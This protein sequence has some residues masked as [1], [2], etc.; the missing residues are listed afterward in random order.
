[1][2]LQKEYIFNWRLIITRI[3]SLIFF[4]ALIIYTLFPLLTGSAKHSR[5]IVVYG[6]SILSEVMNS[7]IFPSFAE[8]WYDSTGE[9][10]NF[11]SSFAGSGTV[12]NQI[13]M[14]VPAEVAILSL[15]LDAMR[16]VEKNI[17]PDN[18]WRSLPFQ[19]ILNLTPF[20]FL[21]RPGNPKDINDFSDLGKEGVG[22]VHPD[23]LTSGG[24]QW[25]ILAEYGSLSL[26]G[27]KTAAFN[28]LLSIWNNV[29]AQA[30]SARAARTQF[31]NGFGD[32]LITYEQEAL[33]DRSRN[34]LNAE[35]IY[36]HSTILS[37][38]TV[39]KISKNISSDQNSLVNA[40]VNFLWTE[41]AQKIFVKYGFRS[42]YENL[43]NDKQFGTIEKPFMV[44]DLGGWDIAKK[45]IIENIW[46]AK[47]VRK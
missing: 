35:I 40:F 44:K 11:I 8:A 5:T 30:A 34:K 33:Y 39:V 18:S 45:E 28:Q 14:G 27:N 9:T 25:A 10:V 41:K 1:M 22:V 13:I 15:E 36:P 43:S 29:V 12:T 21:V 47:V 19:G 20:I 23:P 31:N 17:I 26:S 4:S 38:H 3:F 24:A 6:F 42:V 2:Q 16:L 46:K 37:E 7:G 32:V